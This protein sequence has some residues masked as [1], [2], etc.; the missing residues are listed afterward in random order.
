MQKISEYQNG[1]V[2]K[3]S[4]PQIKILIGLV[5]LDTLS[6]V[7]AFSFLPSNRVTNQSSLLQLVLTVNTIGI[8]SYGQKILASSGSNTSSFATTFAFGLG[9]LLLG[10]AYRRRLTAGITAFC[11]GAML[12]VVFIAMRVLPVSML[13]FTDPF[14]LLRLSQCF[15]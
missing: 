11:I 14:I 9:I 8:G 1:L 12:F 4:V 5:V 15:L 7:V 6:K 10:V 3:N 13:T 2:L